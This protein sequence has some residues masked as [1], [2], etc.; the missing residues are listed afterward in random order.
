MIFIPILHGTLYQACT[1]YG[2]RDRC[3]PPTVDFCPA[4]YSYK[5]KKRYY[6]FPSTKDGI[7][8]KCFHSMSIDGR[9]NLAMLYATLYYLLALNTQQK[10]VR[11]F[12]ECSSLK[13][14]NEAD[15]LEVLSIL[16]CDKYDLSV[17]IVHSFMIGVM[18]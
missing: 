18:S 8:R 5:S 10:F 15:L 17:K 12:R 14:I 9:I 13:A 16:V 6:I 11:R 1:T 4:K 7:F 2:L 3:C